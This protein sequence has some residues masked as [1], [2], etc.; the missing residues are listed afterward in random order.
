MTEKD[1]G[2]TGKKKVLNYEKGELI[3]K[4]DDYGISIYKIISGSVKIFRTYNEVE[5]PLA[6][7]GPGNIIGEMAFLNKDA[8]VRSASARALED[9]ELEVF[10]PR[11]LVEEYAKTS[12]VLRI[13]I[14]QALSRLLR[15]NRFM[16]QLAVRESEET[17][18]PKGK[19][20]PWI[21]TRAFYRKEVDIA[22]QYRTTREGKGSSLPL[23]G[24]IKDISMTGMC[25]EV[26][27]K[28]ESATS[29]EVGNTF[30]IDAVLPNGHDL[31]LTA[32]IV[33]VKKEPGKVRLGMQFRDLADY[34]GTKRNLGFFL[35]PT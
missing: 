25:L 1:A 8:D 29:H 11:E 30:R 35:M 23:R 13:I 12:A 20:D 21:S 9:T 17:S 24:R 15:I 4:Q 18:Q 26:S 33:S 19:E 14:D 7:L 10:H 32:E 31:K 6:T 16:D 22:C 5:V 2:Q 34:Y 27:A 28:N 3:L